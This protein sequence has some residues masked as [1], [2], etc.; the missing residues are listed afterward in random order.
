VTGGGFVQMFR[1]DTAEDAE[2]AATT[3]GWSGPPERELGECV[4]L[5]LV[6][7]RS[8]RA[9]VAIRSATAY[10]T[11][12]VFDFLAVARG[13]EERDAH[14]LVHEQH[15]AGAAGEPPEAFLR[16]G[17]ELGDGTRASNLGMDTRFRRPN[18]EPA[19]PV[20]MHLSGGGGAA[21][22]GRFSMEYG[23]WLWPLPPPG[24]LRVYVEWP[25]LDLPLS[26]VDVDADALRTA[27][28][29]SLGLWC[30]A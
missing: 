22:G 14:R 6:V 28:Q 8:E 15:L 17:L 12:V 29:R 13:L 5:G 26:S 27:A 11:G 16:V 9:V 19:G 4:P 24:G 3:P 30:G 23:Y 20:L 21:G 18:D 2:P 7:G 1:L 25:A 10:T